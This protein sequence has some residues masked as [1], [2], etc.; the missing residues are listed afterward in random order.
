MKKLETFIFRDLDHVLSRDSR[1]TLPGF[2]VA[3]GGATDG[4]L[5][6]ERGRLSI[7]NSTHAHAAAH[8]TLRLSDGHN[9]LLVSDID[10]CQ[11][12]R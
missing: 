5:G 3:G 1:S 2:L 4:T 11:P 10:T 6:A 8:V 7:R 9:A 12:E